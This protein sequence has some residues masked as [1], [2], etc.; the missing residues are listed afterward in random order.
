MR[1]LDTR[2]HLWMLEMVTNCIWIVLRLIILFFFLSWIVCIAAPMEKR[3]SMTIKKSLPN[4]S[5]TNEFARCL[6]TWRIAEWMCE[7][8]YWIYEIRLCVRTVRYTAMCV[9]VCVC[10]LFA[11]IQT[12]TGYDFNNKSKYV[13][14]CS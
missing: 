4:N 9:C 10:A 1:Y 8:K 7:S 6:F 11:L 13:T 2:I 14:N 12:T 5:R 3:N